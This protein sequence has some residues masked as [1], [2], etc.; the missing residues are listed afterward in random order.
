[1]SEDPPDPF[2]SAPVSFGV[3]REIHWRTGISDTL[4]G[5][6]GY[7]HVP[8]EVSREGFRIYRGKP[9]EVEAGWMG[10]HTACLGDYWDLGEVYERGHG[11][12][13]SQL[14]WSASLQRVLLRPH[15]RIAMRQWTLTLLEQETCAFADQVADRVARARARRRTG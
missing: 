11:Q 5:L 7:V 6:D 8:L 1:M 13:P 9:F 10:F 3:H 2:G 15:L 4:T 12:I 14:E